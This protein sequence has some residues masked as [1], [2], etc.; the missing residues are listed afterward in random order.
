MLLHPQSDGGHGCF[1]LSL[2]G[3]FEGD[4]DRRTDGASASSIIHSTW[5]FQS[6]SDESGCDGGEAREAFIRHGP[7]VITV[8]PVSSSLFSFPQCLCLCSD[9]APDALWMFGV[10]I[11]TETGCCASA[12]LGFD[13][14]IKT[15]WPAARRV[16]L[17]YSGVTAGA[18]LL[19][20]AVLAL[21]NH[22]SL[23]RL[24]YELIMWRLCF[25]VRSERDL[26]FVVFIRMWA[27]NLAAVLLE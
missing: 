18:A 23:T 22:D 6:C 27:F 10:W 1:S 11:H 14:S 25:T 4:A 19:P 15:C 5:I 12:D 9:E 7:G 21:L 2:C 24:F 20:Y 16:A 8:S 13:V 17:T 3:V 26:I